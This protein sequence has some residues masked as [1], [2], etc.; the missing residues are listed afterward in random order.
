MTANGACGSFAIVLARLYDDYNFPVRIAQM[1]VNGVYAAH[2]IVEVGTAHGWAV[3]DPLFD[4]YFVRPDG[5]LAAFADVQGNWAYYRQQLPRH[6][7]SNYR[8]AGVRYSNWTKIPFILPA[9]KKILDLVIGKP[10]ADSISMRTYFL[11]IYDLCFWITLSL[12]IAVFTLT[13]VRLIRSKLFPQKN[14]PLTFPNILKY[15]RLRTIGGQ[16]PGQSQ[17]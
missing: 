9:V 11:R 6:Y 15:L 3:V 14:I 2:N 12:F 5:K 16:V 1:K 10:A 13:L 7:D 17:V 8:Y 4:V